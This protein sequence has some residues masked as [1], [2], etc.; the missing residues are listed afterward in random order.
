MLMSSLI[1]V[2]ASLDV[3]GKEKGESELIMNENCNTDLCC[4]MITSFSS[5]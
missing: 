3:E 1:M 2:L 5:S 4:I